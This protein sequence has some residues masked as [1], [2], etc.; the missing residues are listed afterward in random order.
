[1]RCF[2]IGILALAP[3]LANARDLVPEPNRIELDN[4]AVFLLVEKRDVPLIGI[5]AIISGGAITDPSGMAGMSELVA[6]LMQKGAGER[7]AQAFVEAV[8]AVGGELTASAAL[9]SIAISGEFLS[10]DADLMVE[11]FAD[12]LIRPTMSAAEMTKLRDRKINAIRVVKDTNLVSLLPAYGSAFL[13]GEHPYANPVAGSEASL[14]R[15]EYRDVM[16]YFRDTVVPNNA[17]IAVVG[18]FDSAEMERLLTAAFADWEPQEPTENALVEPTPEPAGRVLLVNKPGTTQSYFW[19]GAGGVAID[20]PQRAELDVANTLLGGRYTSLLN[21][22]LRVESGLTYG[23]H[24]RLIRPSRRGL[25]YLYSYTQ[26]ETTIEAIDMMIDVLESFRADG[27]DA[28]ML[29]SAQ[30]YIRGQYAPR[31]ETSAQLARALA[32]IEHMGLTRDHISGYVEA[33]GATTIEAVNEVVRT[34]YPSRKELTF[35]ILGDAEVIRDQVARYGEVTEISITDP[36]FKIQ[37]SPD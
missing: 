24:S 36:S 4:G 3:L 18:D 2:L 8:A 28:E 7:S 21:N 12:M 27:V 34:V 30:N 25:V 20:Y 11:L 14:Q 10:R 35:I 17:I 31:F 15:I 9:E 1:M 19:L 32:M 33:V 26:T 23:A 16:R 6:S 29:A 13:F 5:E 22:A 37:K